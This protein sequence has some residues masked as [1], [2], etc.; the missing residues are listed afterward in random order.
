MSPY[1]REL[2]TLTRVD[3][4]LRMLLTKD[5]CC[6]TSYISPFFLLL[7]FSRGTTMSW[8]GDDPQ[9]LF[10]SKQDR[11]SI[12][13]NS[14]DERASQVLLDITDCF[15]HDHSICQFSAFHLIIVYTCT[16]DLLRESTK[17][18]ND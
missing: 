10:S 7:S 8:R 13:A 17:S 5:P 6:T 2:R 9:T 18:L 15:G 4:M 16:I 14:H 1:E 12:K 11:L 3:S